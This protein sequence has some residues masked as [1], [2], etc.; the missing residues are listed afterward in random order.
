V[1]SLAPREPE[2][3]GYLINY[4]EHDADARE[5]PQLDTAQLP[6]TTITADRPMLS[7]GA[8]GTPFLLLKSTS[9]Y[10]SN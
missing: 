7:A 6:E 1:R 10:H 4:V 2:A 3:G 5:G 8:L 9:L